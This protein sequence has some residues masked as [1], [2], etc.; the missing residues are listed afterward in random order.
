MATV[1]S[2]DW[3]RLAKELD[4]KTPEEAEIRAFEIAAYVARVEKNRRQKLMLKDGG[5]YFELTLNARK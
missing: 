1:Q 3:E 5:N 2:L 4:L